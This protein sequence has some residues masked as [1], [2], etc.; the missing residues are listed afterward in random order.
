M[1]KSITL[2]AIARIVFLFHSS[3]SVNK[4]TCAFL[5]IATVASVLAFIVG[6]AYHCTLK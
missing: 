3:G 6:I 1:L 2:L 5:E 4:E